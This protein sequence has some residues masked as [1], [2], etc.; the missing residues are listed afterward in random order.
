MISP[1]CKTSSL[2]ESVELKANA[3]RVAKDFKDENDEEMKERHFGTKI[4][5][6]FRTQI[7]TVENLTQHCVKVLRRHG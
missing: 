3:Q 7:K 2:L 6:I 1:V 5:K 4:S